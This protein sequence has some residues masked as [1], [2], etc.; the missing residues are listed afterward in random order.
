[1]FTFLK[2]P[3]LAS[4][5][6]KDYLHTLKVCYSLFLNYQLYFCMSECGQELVCNGLY[7]IKRLLNLHKKGEYHLTLGNLL[8]CLK[9]FHELSLK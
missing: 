2:Q 6:Y 1:M 4:C 5:I 7:H 8:I 3:F 9:A